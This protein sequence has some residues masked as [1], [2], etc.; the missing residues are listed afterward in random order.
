MNDE[1]LFVIRHLSFVMRPRSKRGRQSD[2]AA[3]PFAEDLGAAF[4]RVELDSGFIPIQDR[5]LDPPVVT[6]IR[7][8]QDLVKERVGDAVSAILR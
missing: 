1:A 7:E 5:P 3:E 6:S 2:P 8:T 4:P